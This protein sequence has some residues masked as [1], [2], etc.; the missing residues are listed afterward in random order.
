MGNTATVPAMDVTVSSIVRRPVADVAAHAIDVRSAAAW[1]PHVL[2]RRVP[3]GF[4]IAE[5]DAATHMTL[6]S[7]QGPV[8][9]EATYTWEP[10]MIG[11]AAPI[12]EKALA[13]AMANNL[14]RLVEVLETPATPAD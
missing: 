9:F 8:A 6:R 3:L 5:Y 2:G 12:F 11:L 4:E 13:W 10:T 1:Q 7:E 14:A